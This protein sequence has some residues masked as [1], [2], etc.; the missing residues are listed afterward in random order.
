MWQS[1]KAFLRSWGIVLGLTI[2]GILVAFRFVSPAPPDTLRLAVSRDA[3]S[4]Y[5]A[6]VD[7]YARALEAERFKVERVPSLGSVENLRLLRERRVDMALVQGGI[8][9][10]T[11]A[12]GAEAAG[13]LVSL[14]AVFLEPAWVFV[15]RQEAGGNPVQQLRG[16][17]VAVG[18]EG[19]GTRV[20]ALALLQ[21]NG[22]GGDA[23][24]PL[25]FSGNEAAEALL[26]GQAEAAVFVSAV[27]TEA[28]MRLVRSE[29]VNLLNFGSRADAY[30]AQLRYLSIARL[31]RS[32]LSLP[33]DL[34]REDITMM[35]PSAALVS[36]AD[37][38]PQVAALMMRV[39][40]E[41]HR[42]RTL[43]SQE[44]R[45]PNGTGTD[46]PLQE[47]AKNF[48]ER[49]ES[50]LQRYL[51]FWLAVAVDRLWVL[52]IPLVTLLLPLARIAPAIYTWQM[53]RKL[54]RIY[55]EVRKVEEG[56][57]KGLSMQSAA[58]LDAL[59]NEAS[60][61]ELPD[62][63]GDKIYQLRQHIAW[64]RDKQLVIGGT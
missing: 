6:A 59:E 1:V 25:P 42:N 43:F 64:L 45:F 41:S 36:H 23:I 52:I 30:A 20:L 63:Y 31:P 24:Q 48:Y 2:V 5:T 38:N 47:D 60:R 57:G 39:L 62:S 19:S 34:P 11:G 61:L 8:V 49:G 18:P 15:R 32:G 58:K 35:A 7:A 27:P 37:L 21:A 10:N 4:A 29:G 33:E 12:P 9:G 17:R 3:G 26:N 56:A 16:R 54:N 22:L 13:D 51:P 55:G 50:F 14:G 28:I 46:L 40:R 44:G 53:E